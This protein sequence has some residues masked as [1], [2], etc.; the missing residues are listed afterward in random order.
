MNLH[1]THTLYAISFSTLTF[2]AQYPVTAS[3]ASAQASYAG[4]VSRT[5]S[6]KWSDTLTVKDMGV[7]MNGSAGDGN[8]LNAI[9]SLS[10]DN[11]TINLPAGQLPSGFSA[12]ADTSKLL[13]FHM[14]GDVTTG[15]QELETFGGDGNLVDGF[16]NG[17]LGFYRKYSRNTNMRPVVWFDYTNN[18][19]AGTTISSPSRGVVM[20]FTSTSTSTHDLDGLETIF[21]SN[22]NNGASAYDVGQTIFMNHYGTNWAWGAIHQF[23][24]ASGKQ[25]TSDTAEYVDEWDYL[26][27]GPDNPASYYDPIAGY[28]TLFLMHGW[29]NSGHPSW[30][31]GTVYQS[32]DVRY[33]DN[34]AGVTGLFYAVKGGKSGATAPAWTISATAS[35]PVTDGGVQWAYGSPYAV[36][37]A[38]FME[39]N[40]SPNVT[41]GSLLTSD[42]KFY[43]SPVDLS[44]VTF[45]G[46][47]NRG[48]NTVLR[49]PA[50]AGLDF[51]GD[52]TK[53]GQNNHWLGYSPGARALVYM[54]DG[55]ARV[56]FY[57][58][59]ASTAKITGALQVTGTIQSG[60][61]ITVA[62]GRGTVNASTIVSYSGL[63]P[64]DTSFSLA[65]LKAISS[66]GNGQKAYCSDCRLNG[67]T[68]VEVH[69]NGV[70]NVWLDSQNNALSN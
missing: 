31:A 47:N 26:G 59:A 6:D 67:Y 23:N 60:A 34:E 43:N 19:Q 29:A 50:N 64:A 45:T 13:R 44:E 37:I 28:R 11:S 25:L 1:F 63:S 12:P 55:S 22:G 62:G 7:K 52:G 20:N 4:S 36:E 46:A 49:M 33:V 15:G 8:T 38:K 24:S 32:G 9:V 40:Q 16:S 66:S 18:L 54:V 42:A 2:L 3:A 30:T 53:A 68:G 27:N 69:W 41:W 39:V 70:S 58:D 21:N 56:A 65:A 35:S 5:I 51:T 14:L 10:P 17:V 61:D 48:Y 57:D